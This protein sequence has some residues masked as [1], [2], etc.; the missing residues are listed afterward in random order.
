ML[1][2]GSS[3]SNGRTTEVGVDH[4]GD[5]LGV[6]NCMAARVSASSALSASVHSL[7]GPSVDPKVGVPTR[8]L[9]GMQSVQSS[10]WTSS[11]PS[12]GFSWGVNNGEGKILCP[13]T[14]VQNGSDKVQST[15]VLG[16]KLDSMG[17][18]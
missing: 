4:V 12:S 14:S 13:G 10:P 18:E 7:S 15:G 11:K 6:G 3:G 17:A 9:S 16:S 5:G 2:S 1:S 8:T